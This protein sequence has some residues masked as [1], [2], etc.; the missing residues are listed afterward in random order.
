[1]SGTQ[2][3]ATFHFVDW[4][5]ISGPNRDSA[6]RVLIRKQAMSKAAAARRKRGDWG[7]RKTIGKVA[8]VSQLVQ[9]S[10]KKK[11]RRTAPRSGMGPGL[12][13]PPHS[14]SGSSD[15]DTDL[16]LAHE[17]LEEGVTTVDRD[18]TRTY[19]NSMPSNMA[20]TGYEKLRMQC[21]FDL[22]DLSA[23]TT[24]HVG[25]ITAQALSNKPL[26]LIDVLQFRQWSYFSYFPSRYGHF[27]CLDD[28][29]RCVATRVRHWV[30]GN[31][32]TNAIVLSLYARALKSLQA[33]LNDPIQCMKPEILCATEMLSIYELLD[34]SREQGWA[35][36]AAGAKSLV[37]LRGPERFQ[38]T[39]EKALF[40]AQIGPIY[41]EALIENHDCFLGKTDWQT[42][43]LS[44]VQGHPSTES[45]FSDRGIIV[46]SLWANICSLP[47]LYK[48]VQ[49][50]IGGDEF[51][52]E[53]KLQLLHV[54]VAGLDT[55]VSEWRSRY[56]PLLLTSTPGPLSDDAR[57]EKRYE[58]LGV[59]LAAL[60]ILKR[61]A[62]ALDPLCLSASE[63]EMEAQSLAGQIVELE[64]KAVAANS[65]AALFMCFKLEVARATLLTR[66][67]WRVSSQLDARVG[68]NGLIA[69]WVFEHW[70]RLKGRK[71]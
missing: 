54:R 12:V 66:D 32:G 55:K 23:M 44:I 31:V 59:C 6:T 21:N 70:C 43:L 45:P 8:V 17:V 64:Q 62:V 67:E 30:E 18:Q 57:S 24:F 11:L 28:A 50:A 56:G 22:L 58:T 2:A 27:P 15:S 29:A 1:M 33:G 46:V 39:F 47:S 13:T 65:R 37:K 7:K 9:K 5:E 51:I 19:T 10:P 63:S 42:V 25:R 53:T 60:I 49:E 71:V 69:P 41:T 3:G 36:H 16:A 26:R 4:S 48:D 40:M 52:S 20:T 14:V 35:Q 38:S 61:L 34:N 68:T